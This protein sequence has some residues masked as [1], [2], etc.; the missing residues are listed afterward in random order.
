M[1]QCT[2]CKEAKPLSEYYKNSKAADGYTFRCKVCTS[3]YYKGYNASR[4]AANA[5]VDIK[6]KVCRECGLEKPVSQFG[7]KETSLDKYNIYC[8]P[9]WR[10]RCA[11]A[12][13]KM[14]A[15]GR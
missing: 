5:R 9:C 3:S 4:K 2:L 15:N 13:R 7:R 6:S 8:K 12:M 14:Y 1:K 10:I 11:K